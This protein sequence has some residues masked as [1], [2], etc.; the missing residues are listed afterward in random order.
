MLVL[1]CS[2]RGVRQIY[3]LRR[4]YEGLLNGTQQ[5]NLNLDAN[6]FR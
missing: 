3:R 5:H 2:L 4:L 6:P 1:V